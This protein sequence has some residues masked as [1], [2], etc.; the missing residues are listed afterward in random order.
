VKNIPI[1]A[2]T[3]TASSM[4]K[5]FNRCLKNSTTLFVIH[6]HTTIVSIQNVI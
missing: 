2:L 3:V 6:S 1:Y 5:H 4:T